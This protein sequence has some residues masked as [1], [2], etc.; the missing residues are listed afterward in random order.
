MLQ[1]L[2]SPAMVAL[3]I[4]VSGELAAAEPKWIRSIDDA[5]ALAKKS[6]KSMM[7]VFTG[8]GWCAP[9]EL[10]DQK[11]FRVEGFLERLSQDYVLVE[12]DDNFG[13][14]EAQRTKA[15]QLKGLQD[16][17]LVQG[18][19]TIVLSD[20]DG[21]PFTILSG[22]DPELDSRQY[23][24]IIVSA[25]DARKTRDSALREAD[26]LI[27][28]A[29]A[30]KLDEALEVVASRLGSL[31]ERGTDPLLKFY[32][33]YVEE[34]LELTAEA[35]KELGDKYRAR[36]LALSNYRSS[37]A[38]RIKEFSDRQDNEGALAFIQQAL[39]TTENSDEQLTLMRARVEFQK[40]LGRYE[41]ALASLRLAVRRPEAVAAG[42]CKRLGMGSPLLDSTRPSRR[43]SQT[44]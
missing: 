31:D 21:Q 22:Y 33:E 41:D 44:L 9:C 4:L 19:P 36:K 7:I 26:S 16:S 20:D 2:L 8:R 3:F 13:V 17:Y 38:F 37:F 10:L 30:R 40:R 11:V 42:T 35:G 23:L 6:G 25:A 18:V 43:G 34:I 32:T 15:T 28:V 27:G 39:E 24:E 14:S 12:L 5:M 29:R 1:K